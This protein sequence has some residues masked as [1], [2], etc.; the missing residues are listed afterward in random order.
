MLL[1]RELLPAG[2]LQWFL[3]QAGGSDA[4]VRRTKGKPRGEKRLKH[5]EDGRWELPALP[6]RSPLTRL[7]AGGAK[8][9]S[10]LVSAMA[11]PGGALAGQSVPGPELIGRSGCLNEDSVCAGGAGERPGFGAGRIQFVPAAALGSS[12]KPPLA[13]LIKPTPVSPRG[14]EGG[15]GSGAMPGHW[16]RQ[17]D[18]D[19]IAGAWPVPPRGARAD[20][21]FAELV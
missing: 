14:W 2:P 1:Q 19:A 11:A 10:R 5:G 12:I 4:H 20:Q 17:Q 15:T 3:G 18:G 7:G 8:T 13:F 16:L 6:S 21:R 9:A